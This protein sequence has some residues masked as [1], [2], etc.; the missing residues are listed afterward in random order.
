[1][2]CRWVVVVFKNGRFTTIAWNNQIVAKKQNWFFYFAACYRCHRMIALVYFLFFFYLSQGD[3]FSSF[4][5]CFLSLYAQSFI[6]IQFP[7]I[8]IIEQDSSES[9]A[10]DYL[11]LY[12]IIIV[13]C[14]LLCLS[15]QIWSKVT[16]VTLTMHNQK[17][18]NIKCRNLFDSK[19]IF[20]HTS[21]D[22]LIVITF[23]FREYIQ[24][25]VR[26]HQTN[27]FTTIFFSILIKLF[28]LC[29]SILHLFVISSSLVVCSLIQFSLFCRL[30]E[31]CEFRRGFN[32][33]LF[34]WAVLC[35]SRIMYCTQY[36][37][38]VFLLFFCYFF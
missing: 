1:M 31:L 30:L 18:I 32:F 6:Y 35:V 37:C 13:D 9:I 23:I 10:F 28:H 3:I 2:S 24:A 19:L 4:S 14:I 29:T 15:F 8:E 12:I 33:L 5:C 27:D 16:C 17:H 38:S 20:N 34:F 7:L 26:T 11:C 25:R 22:K 21:N 36:D